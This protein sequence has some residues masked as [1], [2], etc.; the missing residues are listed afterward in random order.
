[1]N[2]TDDDLTLDSNVAPSMNEV[3]ISSDADAPKIDIHYAPF[4][5]KLSVSLMGAIL[6]FLRKIKHSSIIMQTY[7]ET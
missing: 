1:M 6:F 2:E 3:S 7:T 4:K 5:T